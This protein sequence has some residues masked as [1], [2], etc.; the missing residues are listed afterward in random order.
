MIVA[1]LKGCHAGRTIRIGDCEFDFGTWNRSNIDIG[2]V[3]CT[4]FSC[5]IFKIDP[6]DAEFARALQGIETNALQITFNRELDSVF[7][8]ATRVELEHHLPATIGLR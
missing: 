4:I 3:P 1:N 2:S 5:G 6:I 8:I 7:T